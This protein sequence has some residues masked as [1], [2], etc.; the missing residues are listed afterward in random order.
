MSEYMKNLNVSE[1]LFETC[2]LLNVK[3][4][5]KHIIVIQK[6]I[7]RLEKYPTYPLGVHNQ[8]DVSILKTMME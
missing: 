2:V 3:Q 6:N 7:E 8:E 1:L 5:S 4:R